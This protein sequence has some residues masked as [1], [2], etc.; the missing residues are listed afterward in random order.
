M[1]VTVANALYTSTA[2]TT[3]TAQAVWIMNPTTVTVTIAG[4]T[5]GTISLLS[6]VPVTTQTS[7]SVSGIPIWFNPGALVAISGVV[8]VTTAASVSV[9]AVPV[10]LN[11]TQ[12]VAMSGM[13]FT[14]AHPDVTVTVPV[15]RNIPYGSVT[16]TALYQEL[17]VNTTGQLVVTVTGAPAFVP[18]MIQV[19][20]TA[21]AQSAAFY[22]MTIWTGGTVAGAGTTAWPVPA[23]KQFRLLNIQAVM[24]TS[25]AVGG[26]VQ[27][28]VVAATATASMNSAS[29]RTQGFQGLIQGVVTALPVAVGPLFVEAD[30]PAATTIGV[31]IVASTAAVL[32]NVI[33]QG[34]LF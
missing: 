18:V 23:G 34:Y 10:W 9:S 11:P 27:F 16:G 29:F 21:I 26:T 28:V 7:V 12:T 4:T 3:G 17:Q 14:T 22:A 5:T 31:A 32:Q 33:V 6:I 13:V 15:I 24:T 30:T 2:V 20:S 8:P 19:S 1:T 25:A